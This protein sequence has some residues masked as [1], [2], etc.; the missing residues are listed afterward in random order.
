MRVL[1]VGAGALGS[2]LGGRLLAARNSVIFYD[3]N[4]A[5]IQHLSVH[6]LTIEELDGTKTELR[7]VK[8]CSG[9]GQLENPPDLMLITVKSYA[10]RNAV[11][12]VLNFFDP[13]SSLF[14]SLQNGLGNGE[15][16]AQLVG[17]ERVL[18]GTTAQGATLVAP[19]IVKHGGSGPTYIGTLSDRAVPG[20]DDVIEMFNKA[21]IETH[22]RADVERLI[23]E[24]LIVNV[25]INA[26]TALTEI[27]NGEI[28]EIGPATDVC[29]RAVDEA[30]RV[31]NA[32]G[33]DLPEDF[34]K[35]V[36]YVANATA[37]NK[38]SMRQ[39]MELGRKTEI[40]YING[41][42]VTL[43]EELGIDTPVNWT[44]TQLIKVKE[45]KREK[46]NDG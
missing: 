28:P 44:L 29:C 13:K 45:L 22:Y 31:A 21:G 8:A 26:I 24:K 25:G 4:P 32:R 35:R 34:C 37:R 40:D 12:H 15:V 9:L 39:D 46:D 23:W 38:S 7:A 2:L 11:S 6:G 41:A 33:L 19:G 3:N 18:V 42:V 30:I 17:A 27:L 1:I 43:G 5:I 10:T 20:I 36:L 14:L 16:I